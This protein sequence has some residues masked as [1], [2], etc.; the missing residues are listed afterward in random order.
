MATFAAASLPHFLLTAKTSI[1]IEHSEQAGLHDLCSSPAA[2]N[3]RA[4]EST[5]L[6]HGNPPFLLLHAANVVGLA[7]AQNVHP[8]PG[9]IPLA[10]ATASIRNV[11]RSRIRQKFFSS[12]ELYSSHNPHF[13]G[14]ISFIQ[15]RRASPPCSRRS[16][17]QAPTHQ[18]AG[19]PY[20]RAVAAGRN[21]RSEQ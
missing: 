8:G 11:W 6:P 3:S 21:R 18:L 16:G 2:G 20:R 15:V 9:K 14:I 7:S 12:A 10:K 19:I 4:A 17:S 1:N 5:L 13:G